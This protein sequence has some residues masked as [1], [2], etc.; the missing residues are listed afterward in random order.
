M[1]SAKS[2]AFPFLFVA[3]LVIAGAVGLVDHLGDETPVQVW[4]GGKDAYAWDELAVEVGDGKS[5]WVLDGVVDPDGSVWLLLAEEQEREQTD[6]EEQLLSQVTVVEDEPAP[7]RGSQLV[8]HDPYLGTTELYR[9]W[10]RGI[11]PVGIAQFSNGSIV[12]GLDRR[13]HN[14]QGDAPEGTPDWHFQIIGPNKNVRDLRP[15]DFD[16]GSFGLIVDVAVHGSTVFYVSSFA[17]ASIDTSRNTFDRIL[18]DIRQPDLGDEF[19]DS[20]D[21]PQQPYWRPIGI[22]ADRDHLWV[23][24]T[25]YR[26]GTNWG[27]APEGADVEG[28]FRIDRDPT[29]PTPTVTPV[30]VNQG[31]VED[32]DHVRS[33]WGVDVGPDGLLVATYE[34]I[35]FLDRS[36]RHQDPVP[37][38]GQPTVARW[39]V[40]PT[41]LLVSGGKASI[42]YPRA[43]G[44]S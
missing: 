40:G 32:D 21:L 2:S 6:A 1:A 43:A 22:T 38:D 25:S 36:D 11:Y 31:D 10:H 35:Q 29:N 4:A 27:D 15:E 16:V 13:I 18:T 26:F 9:E 20:A 17:V 19:V 30:L 12:V 33:T 14:E 39:G 7:L 24:V 41:V 34:A 37:V 23:S 44:R 28:V 3:G 5:V 8:R 42:G